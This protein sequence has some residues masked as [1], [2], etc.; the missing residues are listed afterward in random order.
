MISAETFLQGHCV[1]VDDSTDEDTHEDSHRVNRNRRGS[2]SDDFDPRDVDACR[3]AALRLLDAAPRSCG[4]L[5]QR[6]VG[7]GYDERAVDA[8]IK[9]LLELKLLDD[10]AYA[11]SAV[12]YCLNR[13]MG[14]RGAVMELRRKGINSTLASRVVDEA[15]HQG[16]FEE[17]AWGLGRRIYRK[18]QGLDRQVRLRRFWAAGGR[19]GHDPETL[20]RVA[21]ELMDE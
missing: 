6:L 17:S 18:T 16:L 1:V 2:S 3:E 14:E 19:K 10:R 5:R 20:R 21:H 7:K 15:A 4:G 11:E 9:R 12:R 13:L 8:V